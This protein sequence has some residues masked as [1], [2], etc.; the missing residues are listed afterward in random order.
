M[1][2][3]FLLSASSRVCR[4]HGSSP[5][6]Q[7]ACYKRISQSITDH[8]SQ[9]VEKKGSGDG[10]T[11][12][13]QLG[14]HVLPQPPQGRPKMMPP[15]PPEGKGVRKERQRGAGG[16]IERCS[17]PM[18][19]G[20]ARV[21]G[22]SSFGNS[23]SA[24]TII[25]MGGHAMGKIGPVVGEKSGGACAGMPPPSAKSSYTFTCAHLRFIVIFQC[26]G[27]G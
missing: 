7:K 13:D 14:N 27:R 10:Q 3:A 15:R 21:G 20:S 26:Q 18:G 17:R 1:S 22:D 8:R 6:S 2:V 25:T 16:R 4:H 12:P 9:K 23:G 11:P 24:V 19:G 5:E